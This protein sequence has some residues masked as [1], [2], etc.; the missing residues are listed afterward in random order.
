MKIHNTSAPNFTPTNLKADRV[1]IIKA[2][3]LSRT[4]NPT[5]RANWTQAA[6]QNANEIMSVCAALALSL[7]SA[8][9]EAQPWVQR[10]A[11]DGLG[12]GTGSNST[13]SATAAA[14]AFFHETLVGVEIV[15]P[16]RVGIASGAGACMGGGTAGSAVGLAA[17]LLDSNVPHARL[18]L[19]VLVAKVGT[20]W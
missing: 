5:N 8:A 18:A 12:N 6:V 9:P 7:A 11:S 10:N 15:M 4:W 3:L 19:P 17:G 2:M 20:A 1:V 13:N 16:S 14:A